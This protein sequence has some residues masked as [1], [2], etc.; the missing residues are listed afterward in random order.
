ME[1]LVPP[2][3]NGINDIISFTVLDTYDKHSL[4]P[5]LS[6]IRAGIEEVIHGLVYFSTENIDRWPN[7]TSF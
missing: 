2:V 7:K 6:S 1:Y 4:I 5:Y 3:L